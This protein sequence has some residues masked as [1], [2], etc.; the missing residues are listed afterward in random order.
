MDKLQ[1]IGVG[2]GIAAEYQGTADGPIKLSENNLIEQLANVNVIAEW[3]VIL[4]PLETNKNK[5]E[6][7]PALVELYKNLA[8][9]VQQ[10]ITQKNKLCVIGG[11]HSCA[12]GTWKGVAAGV[13]DPSSLGLIW[14]DA[15]FDAHT[16]ETSTS[17]NVH[18]MPV[19]T[20]LGRG[21]ERLVN[22]L[23]D[24]KHIVPENLVIIGIRS[25]EPAEKQLIDKLGVKVIYMDKIDERS[26]ST[27]FNEAFY[28]LNNRV[29]HIGIT[30]DLDAI[31]PF[32]APGVGTPEPNGIKAA[33]LL[34]VLHDM[35]K[36]KLCCFEIAEYNPHKDKNN[37]TEELIVKLIASI[38][39]E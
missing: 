16:P 23:G 12:I 33:N 28:E 13:G 1:L 18:G 3:E 30:L 32:D 19:A 8:R 27:V 5:L 35:P 39:G 31:D 24:K 2:V 21:D 34:K 17:S 4:S 10:S 20:L 29:E 36:E 7:I 25:Y 26:L 14:I 11:D 9:L 37:K 6:A 15:H 38:Y 22:L